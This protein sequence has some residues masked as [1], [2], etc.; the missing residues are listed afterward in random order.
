[1]NGAVEPVFH[2]L[3][4]HDWGQGKT[5]TALDVAAGLRARGFVVGGFALVPVYRPQTDGFR[6]VGY[7]ARLHR[8]GDCVPVCHT[9]LVDW[10]QV[11]FAEH[12]TLQQERAK[13]A[14][15]FHDD[16]VRSVIDQAIADHEDSSVDA[17]VVD[18]IGP[19]LAYTKKRANRRG[20]RLVEL[21]QRMLDEPKRFSLLVIS[22]TRSQTKEVLASWDHVKPS[23]TEATHP[24]VASGCV[25]TSH[26][27]P[28]NV[29]AMAQSLLANAR[30]DS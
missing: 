5:S 7:E 26:L 11:D 24:L 14:M 12:R 3:T 8:S 18:E 15:Y 23:I 6:V 4:S 27:G 29:L 16:A 10:E 21:V 30:L 13:G 28:D 22:D 17:M 1:M 20:E 9:E 25:K 2:V 19:V